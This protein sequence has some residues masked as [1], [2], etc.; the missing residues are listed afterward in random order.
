MQT[1]TITKFTPQTS[2]QITPGGSPQRDVLAADVRAVDLERIVQKLAVQPGW[3]LA[4]AREAELDYRRFLNLRV[5]YPG[6]SLVPTHDIDEVWH[7]HILDTRAYAADCERLFGGF[8]HHAPSF[9]GGERVQLEIGFAST[10]GLWLDVYAEKLADAA[11][12]EGKSCHADSEC[13]CR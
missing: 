6:T 11:R 7:G 8:L 2:F 1:I 9:G 13:R 5:Q 12:C 10:Q 4:R 3:S